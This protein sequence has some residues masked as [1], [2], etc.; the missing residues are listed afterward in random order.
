MYTITADSK[1]QVNIFIYAVN[2]RISTITKATRFLAGERLYNPFQRPNFH[3]EIILTMPLEMDIKPILSRPGRGHTKPM[4]DA[5]TAI[6]LPSEPSALTPC[7]GQA[8]QPW[9]YTPNHGLLYWK[10]QKY[11]GHNIIAKA[12]SC[13]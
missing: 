4:T 13:E 8:K 6:R 5:A 7:T 12:A 11:M 3:T 10:T 1:T 9:H 2:D